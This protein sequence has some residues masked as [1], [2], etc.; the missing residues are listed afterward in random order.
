MRPE[1]TGSCWVD[2]VHL[3]PKLQN[4]DKVRHTLHWF[5][6]HAS[7]IGSRVIVSATRFRAYCFDSLGLVTVPMTNLLPQQ[8]IASQTVVLPPLNGFQ[9]GSFGTLLRTIRNGHTPD[10]ES[11]PCA[12]FVLSYVGLPLGAGY[13]FGF[14]PNIFLARACVLSTCGKRGID[15]LHLAL[16][17][18]LVATAERSNPE[19]TVYLG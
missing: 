9:Q 8:T 13:V 2:T 4:R 1:Y 11:H 14:T 19:I 7:G 10:Q 17:M 18:A 12:Y 16:V 6:R 3:I 15:R 5:G